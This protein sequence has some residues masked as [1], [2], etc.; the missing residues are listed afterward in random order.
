MAYRVL[1]VL[2]P[3]PLTDRAKAALEDIIGLLQKPIICE[4]QL[5]STREINALDL[6]ELETASERTQSD[7]MFEYYENPLAGKVSATT[8]LARG[9]QLDRIGLILGRWLP[10]GLGND[11]LSQPFLCAN[12]LWLVPCHSV[13]LH[14]H[15][16]VLIQ[17]RGEG[18]GH[19]CRPLLG[20][21]AGDKMF[22]KGTGLGGCV[23]RRQLFESSQEFI[24]SHT[25][26]WR[27]S[28]NIGCPK[29]NSHSHYRQVVEMGIE[30]SLNLTGSLTLSSQGR[31]QVGR[32]SSRSHGEVAVYP[33]YPPW[34]RTIRLLLRI[35]ARLQKPN[36][37]WCLRLERYN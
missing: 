7:L 10:S 5:K 19:K 21:A 12:N 2:P 24:P 22:P 32:T 16:P 18:R 11:S 29:M 3:Y 15:V 36:W 26:A 4:T 9:S 1:L 17:G 35:L 6:G 20:F 27:E 31:A 25:W 28:H 13:R 23:F 33:P 30:N 34:F 8:P 37:R 14:S